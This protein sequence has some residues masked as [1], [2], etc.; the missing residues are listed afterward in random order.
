M[1]ASTDAHFRECAEFTQLGPLLADGLPLA[2]G[3]PAAL[4]AL[5]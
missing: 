5:A 3:D 1:T 2:T 4:A